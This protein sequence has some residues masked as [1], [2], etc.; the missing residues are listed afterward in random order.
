MFN[1]KAAESLK[2]YVKNGGRVLSEARLAWNDERGYSSDVIPGLGLSEVLGVR[3]SK[4]QTL[5]KVPMLVTDNSHEVMSHLK[6]GSFI[7]GSRFAESLE[8][9]PGNKSVKILATFEDKTPGIVASDY[10]KGKT[11]FVGSFLA[12][13]NSRGSLWDQSTQRLVVQDSANKN[14]NEFLLGLVDWAKIDRPYIVEQSGQ[15]DNPLVV[16]MHEHAGGIVLYVLNHGKT[17]EKATIRI[18][19]KSDGKYILNEIL[20]DRKINVKSSEGEIIINT[21]DIPVKN[22][23]VWI[24]EKSR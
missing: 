8:P 4:V 19:V 14:V 18:K 1:K 9:L 10:G 6:P 17:T 23:E 3:E 24:I 15:T 11:I 12:M 22:G 20:R 7:T 16:R 2:E 5:P 13:A 21:N